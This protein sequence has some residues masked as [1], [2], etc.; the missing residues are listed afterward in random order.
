VQL[1]VDDW[2]H[3]VPLRTGLTIASELLRLY[4]DDWKSDRYNV[5]LG[6]QATLEALKKGATVEQLEKSWQADLARFRERRRPYLLYP[7]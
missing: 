6:H 2:Q 1:I 7:E 5:L 4:P 3:F